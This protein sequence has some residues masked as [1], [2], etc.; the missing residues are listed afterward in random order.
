[1]EFLYNHFIQKLLFM[2]P[3]E[4]AHRF[5]LKGLQ[6][7]NH[8]LRIGNTHSEASNPIQLMGIHFP[9][10][11]GLAAGLDKTGQYVDPLRQLGFGFIEIGTI[12][13]R[14]QPG[15][16]KPRLFRIKK[17]QAI[18][19]RMGFNNLGIEK[20]LNYLNKRKIPG[21]LG[22]NIGK[23]FDTPLENAI[24]DYVL[25]FKAFSNIADYIV[26]NISS[27][28]TPGLRNLQTAEYLEPLLNALKTT[29]A[30][31]K[32]YTPLVIKVAPDLTSNEIESISKTLI[33]NQIDG[34]VATNT[35]QKRPESIPDLKGGLSG[36]P[37][38]PY[39]LSCVKQFREMLGKDFPI[40][41]VGGIHSTDDYLAMLNAGADLC[42][43]YTGL[44]Y[45]GPK[46]IQD[47]ISAQLCQTK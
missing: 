33:A 47:C 11:I 44:I 20:C 37:L 29:Q 7:I 43:I 9:N 8:L 14:A 15:N 24:D 32:R 21:I 12:T 38:F 39:A 10:R 35:T 19:N 22:V 34:L 26:V 36:A 27:P 42:Q 5:S 23:N 30:N 13:P 28:N 41:G 25:G 40:I 6:L 46:L 45:Q 3:P 17:S 16:S 31:C 1:M 18:I 4:V 2:L